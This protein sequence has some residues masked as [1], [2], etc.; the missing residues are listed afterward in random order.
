MIIVYYV[1]I[2]YVVCICVHVFMCMCGIALLLAT[3]DKDI[4][5]CKVSSKPLLLCWPFY[6]SC[7][8]RQIQFRNHKNESLHDLGRD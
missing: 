1:S 7:F 3:L 4:A 8:C 5:T 2:A 6:E